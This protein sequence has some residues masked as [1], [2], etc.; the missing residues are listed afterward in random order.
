MG[1]F[2]SYDGT[3]LAYHGPSGANPLICLPGGP[4]QASV[5]CRWRT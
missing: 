4:M 3:K 1:T 5:A 2:S